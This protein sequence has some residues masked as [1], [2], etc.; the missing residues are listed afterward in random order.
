MTKDAIIAEINHTK[1][2]LVEVNSKF[3]KSMS[4]NLDTVKSGLE[5]GISSIKENVVE[6]LTSV[7]D[8]MKNNLGEISTSMES[9]K[10]D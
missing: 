3:S 4:V 10:K 5:S 2:S 8:K 7:N 9:S 6:N 1:D